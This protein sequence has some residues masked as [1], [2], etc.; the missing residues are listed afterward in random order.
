MYLDIDRGLWLIILEGER[1]RVLD[2]SLDRERDNERERDRDTVWRPLIS[3]RLLS[4]SRRIR[5]NTANGSSIV[6]LLLKHTKN[7][8]LIYLTFLIK[9]KIICTI[10]ILNILLHIISI[11]IIRTIIWPYLL[12][13]S[14]S[15][16][17]S[18]MVPSISHIHGHIIWI[19]IR[20]LWLI[21]T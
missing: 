14:R 4:R 12:P 19:I 7:M 11:T 6:L 5:W 15:S 16:T 8:R 20:H 9:F 10:K 18:S 1:L 21:E 17:I 2:R 3:R 13:T